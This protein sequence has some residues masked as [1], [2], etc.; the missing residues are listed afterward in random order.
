MVYQYLDRTTMRKIRMARMA[1]PMP[2]VLA[3]EALAD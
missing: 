2:K 1:I 3:G